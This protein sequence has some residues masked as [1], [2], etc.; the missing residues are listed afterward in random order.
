MGASKDIREAETGHVGQ[1][2]D[3][4]RELERAIRHTLVL[5]VGKRVA[6]QAHRRAVTKAHG[7]RLRWAGQTLDKV[8]DHAA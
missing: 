5:A 1:A 3:H 8:L 2:R 6:D 4:N 7:S